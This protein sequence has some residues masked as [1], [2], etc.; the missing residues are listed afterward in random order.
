MRSARHVGVAG[1]RRSAL[2]DSW[3]RQQQRQGRSCGGSA[4]AAVRCAARASVVVARGLAAMASLRH[5]RRRVSCR[6]ARGAARRS[7]GRS[8]QQRC[9]PPCCIGRRSRVVNGTNCSMKSSNVQ[10]TQSPRRVSEHIWCERACARR[11]AAVATATESCI[12]AACDL[13]GRVQ[14]E[15]WH[16]APRRIPLD[17]TKPAWCLAQPDHIRGPS[18]AAQQLLHP[19]AAAAGGSDAAAV[20]FFRARAPQ[21]SSWCTIGSESTCEQRASRGTSCD[22]ALD[23]SS[24]WSVS[25]SMSSWRTYVTF[26]MAGASTEPGM[27]HQVSRMLAR[28]IA[29]A[30][31][32]ESSGQRARA[33]D[34]VTKVVRKRGGVTAVRHRSVSSHASTDAPTLRRSLYCA[35]GSHHHD[36]VRQTKRLPNRR[37]PTLFT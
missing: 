25:C 1:R 16:V 23:T 37:R 9:R 34:I 3:C 32:R 26:F 36:Y 8:R 30:S 24:C 20:A 2:G 17:E 5:S 12:H 29:V 22:V 28:R 4:G 19:Q 13:G 7:G 21:P 31:E 33:A 10:P 27:G 35:D 18:F 11:T 15:V 14:L 6:R